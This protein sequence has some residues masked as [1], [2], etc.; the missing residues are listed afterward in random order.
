MAPGC[1]R[2]TLEVREQGT[3]SLE[4]PEA[5]HDRGER[6]RAGIALGVEQA[7]PI[8]S[9]QPIAP[10]RP[11]L[12]AVGDS[13]VQKER[14]VRPERLLEERVGVLVN[15]KRIQLATRVARRHDVDHAIVEADRG[16]AEAVLVLGKVLRARVQAHFE[17]P[18]EGRPELLGEVAARE[19]EHAEHP[20]AVAAPCEAV[21]VGE[22]KVLRL[23]DLGAAEGVGAAARVLEFF[24]D[25]AAERLRRLAPLVGHLRRSAQRPAERFARGLEAAAFPFDAREQPGRLRARRVFALHPAQGAKPALEF[26][27]AD[28]VARRQKLT[29]EAVLVAARAVRRR[30]IRLAGTRPQRQLVGTQHLHARGQVVPVRQYRAP[31]LVDPDR[32]RA[33]QQD[34]RAQETEPSRDPGEQRALNR[35]HPHK[36]RR[37]RRAPEGAWRQ[38]R[39]CPIRWPSSGRIRRSTAS[40]TAPDDPGIRKIAVPAD[41]PASAR[42]SIAAAPIS[43]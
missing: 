7:A 15:Q 3:L 34:R 30:G 14:L 12:L 11:L 6:N 42:E 43:W 17:R 21:V 18:L 28:V 1:S 31:V 36:L 9:R 27:A 16:E 22:T 4:S 29:P 26:A 37:P 5:A 35:G 38:R 40:R 24:V 13:L 2:S 32:E 39:S 41:V 8:A 20:L 33:R 25:L 23:R 10:V 19:F